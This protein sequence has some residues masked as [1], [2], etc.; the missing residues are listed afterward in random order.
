MGV[1]AMKIACKSVGVRRRWALI[2]A[3]AAIGLPVVGT[4]V[5]AFG[6]ALITYLYTGGPQLF[7]E[8]ASGNLTVASFGGAG[9]TSE[10]SGGEGAETIGSATVSA[11][12]LLQID[13]GGEGLIA[14]AGNGGGGGSFVYDGTSASLLEVAGGGGGGG[15]G[16]VG[17]Q[18]EAGQSGTAGGGPGGAGGTGG[19]GGAATASGAGGPG[20]GGGGGF[21]TAG[22]TN[23]GG[24]VGGGKSFMQGLAG[25]VSTNLLGANGGYGGGGG[26]SNVG[27]GGGGYS[28]G[29]AGS[30][31]TGGGGG[32]GG[33]FLAAGLFNPSALSG[34]NSGNGMVSIE[35]NIDALVYNYSGTSTISGNIS[36]ASALLTQSGTGTTVLTG[37]NTYGG[38]T[39]ISAGSLQLGNGGATGSI[40]G[41]ITDN[42]DL[43]FD[44]SG[45]PTIS[46]KISGSGTLT[47]AGSGVVTL[48]SSNTYTGNTTINSGVLVA[49]VTNALPTTTNLIINSG[50][51]GLNAGVTQ[52]VAS[53]SG[54]GSGIGMSPNGILIVNQSTNT[55]FDGTLY[56]LNLFGPSTDTAQL[57]KQGNGKLTL[58]GGN[59]YGG[60]TTISAG[61]LQIGAGGSLGSIYG[62][63]L[64]N[65]Q[66]TYDLNVSSTVSAIISGTGSLTQKGT[67]T[68]VL[69]A[70]NTYTGGTT[71]SSAGTL[72]LGNGG[73]TG[74][75]SS[76]GAVVDN[77]NLTFDRSDNITFN[78]FIHGNGSLTQAGTGTV[79]LSASNSYLGN[80]NVTAGKLII[81]A[82]NG[83]AESP[84]S[85][86]G[87]AV[88]QLAQ[89][90]GAEQ[91]TGLDITGGGAFDITNN[92][93]IISYSGSDPISTIAGYLASGFAGGAWN[94][95]GIDSSIAALPA[96]SHYGIGY[97]DGA[98]G[99]VAGLT[100]GQ[101]EVMYTL[102]GDAD[103]DGSVTG[104]DFT[105][106][107]SHLGKSVSGWDQGDFFYTG[108]V[109]GSDF[110]AL[111]ANL[112]KSAG[113]ANIELPASD[114]VAIDAF[115][116]ANG[117]MA[118]VPEPSTLGLLGLGAAGVLS[119]RRRTA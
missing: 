31:N 16:G 79:T 46:S 39:T 111:V 86:S 53:L 17:F 59:I 10:L 7:T 100:S 110:T 38:A 43:T 20:G 49:G 45:G 5:P 78:N 50:Y 112:G 92:H 104:S 93:V 28:G 98:D 36:G 48:T 90:T 12:D 41:N 108:T 21:L 114:Y 9:G 6:D 106:L 37:S 15:D 25:G 87:G 54:A 34:V 1:I 67:N 115:A 81:G 83:I 99:V 68:L 65:A 97:A 91:I 18:G 13:V 22:G 26:G 32:G 8:P 73:T 88:L 105:I 103:L 58:A 3:A 57:I 63:I 11:Y 19:Q 84:V 42:A 4:V 55:E 56:D 61:T 64:D 60:G 117:L 66:L 30:S 2:S 101:I 33:S 80:T 23:P 74:S 96:N 29:G 75:I 107:A 44:L 51:L 82:I 85:I 70:A 94:G 62:N 113:G 89:D 40:S 116:V 27:G 35:S 72:Q 95:P 77:G 24:T 76:T 14:S 119:R 71:I 69:T 52:T 118:D 102:Y 109:T 47:Q